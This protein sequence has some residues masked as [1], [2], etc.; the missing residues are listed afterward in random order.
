M[1]DLQVVFDPANNPDE[2]RVW[3]FSLRTIFA[4]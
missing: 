1:P 3:V 2:D 4:F